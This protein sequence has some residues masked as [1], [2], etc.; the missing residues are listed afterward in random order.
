MWCPNYLEGCFLS[1]PNVVFEVSHFIEDLDPV[2]LSVT[3]IDQAVV[4]DDYTMHNLHERATT[5]A[6]ASSFV[7]DAPTDE[8]SSRIDRKQLCG[9]RHNRQPR[10]RRHC[11][12]RLDSA[13]LL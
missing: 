5:S 10:R 7:P 6:S 2:A 12:G 4:A 11:R 8:E 3:D 1:D 9:C 13:L